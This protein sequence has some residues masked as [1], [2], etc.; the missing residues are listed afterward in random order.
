[1]RRANQRRWHDGSG[2]ALGGVELGLSEEQRL[3]EVGAAKVCRTQIGSGD[4]GQGEVGVAEVGADQAGPS[5]VRAAEIG[6]GQAGADEVGSSAVQ[7]AAP[8]LSPDNF[9][10]TQQQSVD[11]LAVP[12]DIQAQERIGRAARQSFGRLQ[13]A[14]Q[15]TVDGA[16]GMQCQRRGQVPQQLMKLPHD[17][18]HLEHL[19]GGS[20]VPAPVPPTER[21][22]ANLL[23]RAE[24]VIGGAA[25][26]ALPPEI[27]VNAAP[28]VCLQVGTGMSGGLVD[29]EICRSRKRRS[30]TAEPEAASAVGVQDAVLAARGNP[31]RIQF[32][33]QGRLRPERKCCTAVRL[34]LSRTPPGFAEEECRPGSSR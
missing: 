28:I 1:M 30:D 24:A 25:R 2:V 18:E 21:D 12:F 17:Q 13:R 22:L 4:I 26:K 9:A 14:A 27:L 20:R 8:N 15:L 5:Q 32:L 31:R 29:R 19:R 34:S 11:A 16:G 7:L 33:A 6:A 3:R 10:G 23:A